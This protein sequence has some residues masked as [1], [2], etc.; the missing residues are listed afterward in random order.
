[1]DMELMWLDQI[2]KKI[3][4]IAGSLDQTGASSDGL[5]LGP[6]IWEEYGELETLEEVYSDCIN[7]LE[8]IQ[9]IRS[10]LED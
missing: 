6:P 9:R 7:S 3:K 4:D 8:V 1:M 2:E 5:P 10:R